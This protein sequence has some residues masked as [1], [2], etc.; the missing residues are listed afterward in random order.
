MA[1]VPF[2]LVQT[3]TLTYS[4]YAAN[5][6]EKNKSQIELTIGATVF[7]MRCAFQCQIDLDVGLCL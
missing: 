6:I 2:V 1:A 5:V 3:Y 7:S 4:K